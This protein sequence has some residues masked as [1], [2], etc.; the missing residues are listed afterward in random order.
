MTLEH[1]EKFDLFSSSLWVGPFGK[2]SNIGI[3]KNF[4]KSCTTSAVKIINS[5]I[6]YP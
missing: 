4:C 6:L 5:A 3:S 1:V 2:A